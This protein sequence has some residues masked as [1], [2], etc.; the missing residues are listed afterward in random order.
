MLESVCTCMT[1]NLPQLLLDIFTSSAGG[2]IALHIYF[3]YFFTPTIF[4]LYDDINDDADP[5]ALSDSS[6]ESS[7]SDTDSTSESDSITGQTPNT[8]NFNTTTS[9]QS[10]YDNNENNN[11]K[12]KKESSEH[13]IEES[14]QD[15]IDGIR[16]SQRE[17]IVDKF[18]YKFKEHGMDSDIS[19]TQTQ[20]L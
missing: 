10:Q 16:I 8:H 2:F 19:G 20:K 1:H 13:S 14:H 7:D 18:L 17:A 9:V 11:E 3:K 4:D 12:N 6:D 5:T 15:I